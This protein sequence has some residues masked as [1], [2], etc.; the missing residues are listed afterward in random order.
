MSAPTVVVL[1]D[2]RD[3]G[4]T[5]VA[6]AVARRAGAECVAVVRPVELVHARWSHRV[7]PAGAASTRIVLPDRRTLD[8][9][10]VGAVLNRLV[11]LPDTVTFRSTRDRDYARAERHALVGSWLLGLGGRV[12]GVHNAFGTASG[13]VGPGAAEAHAARC[14]LPVARCATATRG[15]LLGPTRP[16]TRLVPRLAWPGGAASP[17]PVDVVP[18]LAPAGRVLVCGDRVHGELAPAHGAA[19]R[20]LADRLGTTLLEVRFGR[21]P[22][23]PAVVAANPC[24]ALDGPGDPDAIAELLVELAS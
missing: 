3:P 6:A 19:C 20:A 18:E 13:G 16:G 5:A 11:Q 24:P 12:V 9:Q 4:A 7:D 1:A 17:V 10:T 23:G 8:D 14:G 22:D 2:S 15:G 21:G